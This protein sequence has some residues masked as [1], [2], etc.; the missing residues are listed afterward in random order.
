MSSSDSSRIEN[1]TPEWMDSV[2][3][4]N[5][6]STRNT[7]KNIFTA[8][9]RREVIFSVCQSKGDGGVPCSLVP[10]PFSGGGGYPSLWSRVLSRGRGGY[11]SQDQHMNTPSSYPPGQE[12]DRVPPS[13]SQDQDRVPLPRTQ[14]AMDRIRR[15]RYA[16]CCHAG[17]LSY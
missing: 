12:Q 9:V 6:K 4:N 14:Y 13:P 17:G 16:S 8:R 7:S 11:P 15:G 10:G 2:S 5:H 1:N 3:I